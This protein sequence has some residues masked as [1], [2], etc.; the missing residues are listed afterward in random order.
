MSCL[1]FDQ[2]ILRFLYFN[3]HFSDIWSILSP[4]VFENCN[5]QIKEINFI[6]LE[7]SPSY[8]YLF[9]NTDGGKMGK[10][11]G[12]DPALIKLFCGIVSCTVVV[13]GVRA[14]TKVL[15][16]WSRFYHRIIEILPLYLHLA[17]HQPHLVDSWV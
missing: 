4:I 5:K 14:L 15:N 8:F 2:T 9:S 12:V 6:S 17:E 13:F 10:N 11:K 3:L 1:L 16:F 7:F